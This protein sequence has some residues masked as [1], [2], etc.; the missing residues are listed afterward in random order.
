MFFKTDI[1]IIRR[2]HLA[3]AEFV[4]AWRIVPRT[5][6]VA[7]GWVLYKVIMWYMSL[8]PHLP[9][10]LMPR[11]GDLTPEQIQMLLTA[12]PTTQ[13]AALVTAVV[14]IAAAIFGLYSSSGRKWNG[15]TPWKKKVAEQKSTPP[16]T[17]P[18][19]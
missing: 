1:D 12:A 19:N 10:E 4:D 7:Y 13:H 17:D 6:V 9:E 11:V 16:P 5:I 18:S 3:V 15:F 2:R 14:G 8:E